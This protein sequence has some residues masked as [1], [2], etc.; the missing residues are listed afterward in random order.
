MG[1]FNFIETFFFVS[2]GITFVLISLLVYHFKQRMSGLEQKCD[3]M[4]DII[5]NV[6][7]ELTVIRNSQSRHYVNIPQSENCIF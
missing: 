5:N 4:F 1:I 2:L 3:T 7:K 6:V